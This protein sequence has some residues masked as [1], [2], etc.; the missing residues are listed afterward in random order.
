VSKD[1]NNQQVVVIH[2]GDV[3]ESDEAWLAFLKKEK[4][5]RFE[6]MM[7]EGWKDTLQD[8]LGDEYEVIIPSMPNKQNAKYKEWTIWFEKHIPHFDKNIVLV[9]HSLGGIFVAKY[10]S[11]N[12]YPKEIKATFL[13]AAPFEMTG[14]DY[15]LADFVLVE[16]LSLLE[17]QGGDMYLYHSQDD[18]VVTFADFEKYQEKLPDAQTRVFENKEHFSGDLP[19]IVENIKRVSD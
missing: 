6:T 13:V 4:E 7:D 9:G 19:E 16:D 17:E 5:P 18:A 12:E 15:T 8:D 10:L 3:F 14:M 1:N 11:E 2:G